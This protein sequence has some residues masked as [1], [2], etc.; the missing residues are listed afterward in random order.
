MYLLVELLFVVGNTCI[1]VA[2]VWDA[3]VSL[4]DDTEVFPN[5]GSEN[6]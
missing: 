4:E 6:T 3:L 1:T 5:E 2:V